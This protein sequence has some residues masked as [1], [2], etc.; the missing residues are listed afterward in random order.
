M[1]IYQVAWPILSCLHGFRL[2][3][4]GRRFGEDIR[5]W[6]LFL[7]LSPLATAGNKFCIQSDHGPFVWQTVLNVLC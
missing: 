6:T 2:G 7:S 3:G 4:E 5:R 1:C